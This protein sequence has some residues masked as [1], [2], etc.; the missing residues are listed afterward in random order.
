MVLDDF[1]N[2]IEPVASVSWAEDWDNGGVM[3]RSVKGQASKVAVA[4]DP[5]EEAVERGFSLGCDCLLTHHPLI[6]SPLK[7]LTYDGSVGRA[8]FALIKHDMSAVSCHTSW[9]NSPVGTNVSLGKKLGLDG[10]APIV[11]SQSGGWGEGLVGFTDP[12]DMAELVDLT[13]SAWGL[14]HAKF[15]G[16]A[17]ARISKIALCGGSGGGLWQDALNAGAQVYITGDLKYHDVQDAVA[18][19]INMVQVDHGEM[20]WASMEDLSREISR[21]SGLETVLLEKPDNL[22]GSLA[23]G[24]PKRS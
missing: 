5:T 9:D 14:S 12:V 23:F 15:W 16:D 2:S 21:C 1:M 6:F 4:L 10:M 11:K 3:V 19:G 20:E 22:A 24:G 13:V 18:M 7:K 17:G 8:V